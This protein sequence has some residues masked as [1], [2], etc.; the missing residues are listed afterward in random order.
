MLR[1]EEFSLAYSLRIQ[2]L[3]EDSVMVAGAGARQSHCVSNQKA[4]SWTLLLNSHPPFCSVWDSSL[5]KY[6]AY[7]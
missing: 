1:Q 2:S 5:C 3:I 6:A 7:I 4:E